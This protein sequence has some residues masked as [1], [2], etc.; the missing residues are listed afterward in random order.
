MK[1]GDSSADWQAAQSALERY[2]LARSNGETVDVLTVCDGD[3]ALAARVQSVLVQGAGL[4]DDAVP[5]DTL[6]AQQSFGDFE[7]VR[8]LGRGGMGSVYLARQKSLARMVAVKMLDRTALD[9][10][11]T[12]VRMQ[13]EAELTALLDHP[14]IVPV[15]SVGE[16][17]GT[18]FI[19]MK[20]VP[21][22]SLA[23]V[24]RPLPPERAARIGVDLARA[25]DA[26]HTQGVVHRDV[27]PANI[28]LDGQTPV[29]VDFGLA[30]AQSD[31]TLTQVG[32]V[33]GTL[34]YMAPERLDASGAVADPRIDVYGL[35][36]TLYELL[37][38]RMVFHE[39]APTALVRA[40]LTRD[41]VPLR[42]RGRHHDLETIVL[43]ALAKE[44]ARRFPTAA[45]MAEDLERY[46]AGV[47]VRSRRLSWPARLQRQAQRY[48][49]TTAA[50]ALL[51]IVVLVLGGF[52]MLA[53]TRTEADRQ[54]RL[55]SARADLDG[56][57][58]ARAL[59]TLQ[60]LAATHPDDAA[61]A[62]LAAQA[63]AETALDQLLALVT[64][65]SSN[66]AAAP[67]AA[68]RSLVGAA[69]G[70]SRDALR[71]V[72]VLAIGHTEGAASG[73]REW[74]AL[75]ATLQSCRAGVALRHWLE[76][77]PTPWS[78]PSGREPASAEATLLTALVL[79]LAGHAPEAVLTELASG[80]VLARRSQRLAF[81]EA[82]SLMD[83]GDLLGAE[84]LL[85]ALADEEAQPIV[86][87]WLADVQLRLG[88]RQAARR[89]LGRADA[90]P[91]AEY[92]RLM[93]EFGER[94]EARDH[95]G[96][97]ALVASL[98]ARRERSGEVERFLAEYDGKSSS[99]DVAPALARL[100]NLY[101]QQQHDRIGRDLTLAAMVEVAAWHLPDATTGASGTD[102]V[103][104]REFVERWAN[105]ADELR[106]APAKA[107]A[108]A[109]LARSMCRCG[110]ELLLPG[111]E[112][113]A[114]ACAQ[115]PLRAR[116]AI[117]YADA[118]IN[119]P[120][121]TEPA[122]R[123]AHLASARRTLQSLEASARSGKL[124]LPASTGQLVGYHAWLLAFHAKDFFD[125]VR[126]TPEVRD[127]LPDS[128]VAP[129]READEFVARVRAAMQQR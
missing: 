76:D 125:L 39:E 107:T 54:R 85:R 95:A 81:L 84:R 65:R 116:A 23:E 15:Y 106:H 55:D 87:R 96:V 41:P 115:F 20:Y 68:L 72:L 94:A 91:S 118:V 69:A 36:A 42:F 123:T 119:L 21:G 83:G 29:L 90:S 114:S 25:L 93:L 60:L 44:P 56:H 109:W 120:E 30:R 108:R 12:R 14:N 24:A 17:D 8:R 10:P 101:A 38:D 75:P 117:D 2:L 32:K 9:G 105:R 49:R 80:E 7:L 79:R 99:A 127:I 97:Q 53:A 13:R 103:Q 27:K 112:A 92:L 33:A 22:P 11:A 43:R 88:Q 104:H 71:L 110:E 128:L 47:P 74:Q 50:T 26:A 124:V 37:T 31:P 28:L 48:P 63:R 51:A 98:R 57:R 73:R 78:L 58:H 34:R 111:L 129:A 16:V 18:P 100:E 59:A 1:A 82:M 3:E 40:I 89:S 5:G 77:S 19:A 46:L 4:I 121:S 61:A 45:A 102:Q 62:E 6:P 126:R 67:L 86:W 52:T 35:G 66:V 64:D 70:P 113:F 122:V